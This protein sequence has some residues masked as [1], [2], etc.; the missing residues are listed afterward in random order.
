MS[1]RRDITLTVNGVLC[2]RQI[3][4]RT[5]L[6]DFLRDEVGLTGTHA[7]CEHGVCGVCAVLVDGTPVRSC[8]LFAVQ[9][10][11][12]GVTT[13]EG[14]NAADGALSPIQDAFCETHGMQCGYCTPGMLIAVHDLLAHNA[15]PDDD[16]IREAI[17]G[18]LCRCT[19]YGQI[20]EAVRL[21][22]ARLRQA[23]PVEGSGQ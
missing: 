1:E 17:G 4:P 11:G 12:A 20:I 18:T 13:V 22:A 2:Q 10:E 5:T 15:D 8:L 14:L 19:G 9:L 23:A 16:A 6:L 3:E 21:A 7:G